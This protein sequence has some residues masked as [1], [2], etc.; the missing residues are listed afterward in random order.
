MSVAH[1][2]LLVSTFR[3]ESN[4]P[5]TKIAEPAN[6]NSM[7]EVVPVTITHQIYRHDLC[8][9]QGVKSTGNKHSRKRYEG[10][11]SGA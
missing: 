7:T 8:R 4:L 2:N 5:L 10:L 6:S 11:V 1:L 9:S 3:T